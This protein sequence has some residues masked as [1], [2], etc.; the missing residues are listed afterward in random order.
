M[1]GIIGG[2]GPQ[3]GNNLFNCILNETNATKDQD[4]LPLVLW[5]TP[6]H[7]SDRSQFLIGQ[8]AVNP[9][10][11]VAQIA[12]QM[13]QF[14]VRV[15][16]IPCNTFHA[17][18]IWQ[19]F[20]QSLK[21]NPATNLHLVNMVQET[22]NTIAFSYSENTVGILGT[23][24]TY[25]YNVYGN[26]LTKKQI[27]FILPGQTNQK[28][29][30]QSVYDNGFGIKAARKITDESLEIIHETTNSLVEQGADLILLGCTE[31]SLIPIQKLP[32]NVLFID[33]V[34]ILAKA[35]IKAYLDI[36]PNNLDK[37]NY[38]N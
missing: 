14:G 27:S 38:K 18:P 29:V 13:H 10:I 24:G 35:M 15:V 16:G 6:G 22:A 1:L 9:A 19:V 20:L 26:A 3:A 25:K 34:E 21:V 12:Q 32:K 23:L 31:L 17:Q 33:P 7:I 30:H 2:M 5:S 28:K 36:K 8:T 11:A 37:I 4:H